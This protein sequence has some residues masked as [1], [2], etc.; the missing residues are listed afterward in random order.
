MPPNWQTVRTQG[1]LH[2]FSRLILV[3]YL[4]HAC[5]QVKARFSDRVVGMYVRYSG[6]ATAAEAGASSATAPLRLQQPATFL[7][8]IVISF[9]DSSA[10]AGS[11]KLPKKGKTKTAT[12]AET[13]S[14]VRC[15]TKTDG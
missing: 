14:C 1:A 8:G 12:T 5:N 7:M 10:A 3:S 11:G 15:S 2:V 4:L 9:V 13:A 6:N